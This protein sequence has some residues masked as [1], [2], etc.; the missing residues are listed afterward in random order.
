MNIRPNRIFPNPVLWFLT[1]DY[2]DSDFR[3]SCEVETSF[4]FLRL[5]YDFLLKN[6][7]LHDLIRTK[8]A[9]FSLHIECPLTMYR[10][11]VL[12]HSHK[13]DVHI[14]TSKLSGRVEVQPAVIAL[15]DIHSYENEDLHE[16]YQDVDLHI[17]KGAV[18]A[19]AEPFY[20]QVDKENHELGKKDSIFTFVKNQKDEPMKFDTDTDKIII[21]LKEKDFNAQQMLQSSHQYQPVIYSLF[22][23]PALIYALESIDEDIDLMREKL[24]FRSLE[25]ILEKQSIE[26]NPETVRRK[27]SYALAQDLLQ[28]PVT[29]AL[30]ILTV[31]GGDFE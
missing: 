15:E 6:P 12:V 27:T 13:G 30:S 24:W 21:K 19:V 31:A 14:K 17:R 7:R 25:K 5:K 26:L 16:D 9:A 23:I 3:L 18:L 28:D 11:N 10:K 2:T 1:D 29:A 22:I 4:G 8:K 20:V